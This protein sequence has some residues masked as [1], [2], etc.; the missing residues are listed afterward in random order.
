M[1]KL[2]NPWLILGALGVLVLISGGSYLKGR[3]DCKDAFKIKQASQF[4]EAQKGIENVRIEYR[5]IYREAL[6]ES[7]EKCEDDIFGFI[8]EHMHNPH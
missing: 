8:S 2:L 1:I 4:E 6:N 3:S 7:A 5:N